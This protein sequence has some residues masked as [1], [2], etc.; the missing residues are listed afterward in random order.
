MPQSSN[1][2]VSREAVSSPGV[3][4][5][6]LSPHHSVNLEQTFTLI[7]GILPFEACLYYQVVPL[8]IEGSLLRLGIVNPTDAVAIDYVRRQISY[9]NYT[10]T[11]WKIS[12]D[13]HRDILSKYLS[14]SA[15]ERQ[16]KQRVTSHSSVPGTP[17]DTQPVP[18]GFD[19]QPTLVV[20]TPDEI[21]EASRPPHSPAPSAHPAPPMPPPAPKPDPSVRAQAPLEIGIDP[22][23]RSLSVQRLAKLPPK[24]FMEALLSHVLKDGI[25]RLYFE[26]HQDTGRILWSQDG[27]VQSVIDKLD[28]IVFQS[29]INEYK[30]LTHI[31]LISA[32]KAR[33][34]EIERL[35][36]NER[37][38]LRFR[39]MPGTYGE[40]AT[41]QVLRGT[42]LRFYQQQ[43]IDNLG[44]NA[45]GTAQVLQQRLNEIRER[46]QQTLN[47]VNLRSDTLPVLMQLLR[48][49]E[50][51]VQEMI[52]ETEAA[53]TGQEDKPTRPSGD[54]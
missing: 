19:N 41:L 54:S 17:E 52:R 39:V 20:D 3:A 12:S 18:L 24:A 45:L 14:Y 9:I 11:T 33:Q 28:P 34:A 25:G 40:E 13:W 2:S 35:H 36:N 22:K 31:S 29:V 4:G 16:R 7:D 46:A 50:T 44:Q 6:S 21:V 47:S 10:V 53:Y 49:M 42:A 26:R 30:L 23:Y 43:Q 38:L 37:V 5:S 15:R 27:I 1:E 8:S 32:D 51:Q 48:Q